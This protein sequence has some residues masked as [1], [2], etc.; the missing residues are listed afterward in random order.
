[1]RKIVGLCLVAILTIT[2]LGA[3]LQSSAAD[4]VIEQVRSL[5]MFKA[6]KF[7]EHL[8]MVR[9][10]DITRIL[11]EKS[12][13][14]PGASIQRK[15]MAVQEFKAQFLARNPT[16]PNPAKLQ[17]LLDKERG[18][19][20]RA[21]SAKTTEEEAEQPQIMSLVVPVEFPNEDTF[22]HCGETVTTVGPLHNE[23]PAPGPRDNNSIWFED[24]TPE[25][26]D[27]LYFGVGPKAGVIVNHP[28]LGAVDLRGNTMANY[29]LEQSEGKFVP[30]GLVYP[31]WLTA[32]HSEGWYGADGCDEGGSHNVRAQDLVKEVIELVK[33]DDPNFAWQDFDG[34]GNGLVDNFTVIHAGTGQESGGGLQGD[35]SIWSHA[36]M[37]GWPDGYLVCTAGSA[38]CPDRDIRVLDY[39]M[40]PENIDIG[41]I[42][43]EFGHAAFGLPDLY[44]TDV[45]SSIGD[46][47][48]MEAGSWNGPLAG[49]QPAPFPLWFRMLIGWA[50]PIEYDYT[51]AP[52]IVKVGQHSLRPRGTE[53]GIK[54]NL[55][56]KE[57]VTPNPAGEGQGW[58]SGVADG[59]N[60][61]LEHQFDLTG[62]AAPVF[63]FA[64][65]WSIEEDW[66]GG[67]I[68][69]STDGGA[70]WIALSDMDGYLVQSE[71]NGNNPDLNWVLTGEGT[72]TL[73]FDLAAYAGQTVVVRLRYSTDAAVQEG[74]WWADNI[75]L[76]DGSTVL[77]SDDVENPSSGWAGDWQIV[78]LTNTYPRYYLVEWRNNSG[79]DRG[80][81]YAYSTVYNDEDEW[82]V[83]RVPFTVPGALLY[84]RDASYS[85]D[86]TLA[87]SLYDAPSYGPKH[88]LIVIDSHSYP[89]MWDNYTYASGQNLRISRRVQTADATFTLQKTKP[90]TARLGYDPATGE[91]VDTPLETKTFGPREAVSQFHDSLGYYPGLWY[92]EETGGLYFWDA[93]ASAAVPAQDNYTTKITW[94]DNTPAYDLYGADLGDTILGSGNPG[95]D[96]V[97]YGLHMAVIGQGR[98]GEWGLIELWNSPSVLDL[99]MTAKPTA[100]RAK[101]IVTYTLKVVNTTPVFQSFEVNN[102]IPENTTFFWGWFYNPE[103]NS[104]DWKGVIPPHGTQYLKFSV[105]VNKDVPSGTIIASEASL[106]DGALGDNASVEVT[107]K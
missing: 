2:S 8:R 7:S 96:D 83:D 9:D 11:E 53:P 65:Y 44:T 46:W 17:A 47:A 12:I 27:E 55:P 100:V 13:L 66:D 79:F 62:A 60:F 51:T 39:S 97:Q 50:E 61:T 14:L 36:S 43:E 4:D 75:S 69:V 34:D 3:S 33:V 31:K 49:M 106:T 28:N 102:P 89:Y 23:M 99:T 90:F 78:P 21:L 16:T 25:L 5:P 35:F 32:Q 94:A 98:R 10:E 37:V 82:E 30:E 57:I 76:V 54:V 80:L 92:K 87:D 86:Y 41:V 48:I 29:Y 70:T 68:E 67:Y 72:D 58:W 38:G 71:L 59:V 77:F 103:A 101:G 15:Q 6:S 1:M 95:D 73:R 19:T 74:G 26:Y 64:S 40:D 81:K 85:L 24:A 107:V 56:D 18:V 88:G 93:A 105:K 91:Y 42:A 84:F 22:E 52:A 45:D 63:S 20:M 104:V